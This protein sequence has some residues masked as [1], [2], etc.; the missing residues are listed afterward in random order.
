MR[1]ISP[2]TYFPNLTTNIQEKAEPSLIED[3][4]SPNTL[5]DRRW[6]LGTLSNFGCSEPDKL[7]SEVH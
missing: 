5:G 4:P 1:N 3:N 2:S 7:F 6:T